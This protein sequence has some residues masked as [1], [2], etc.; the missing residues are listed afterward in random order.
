MLF[1]SHRI[2]SRAAGS[3][4]SAQSPHAGLKLVSHKSHD[5][6]QSQRLDQLGHPGAS[7]YQF[8]KYVSTIEILKCMCLF[9]NATNKAQ[10]LIE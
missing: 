6:S 2:Q 1:R 3:E 8:L 10:L 5:L 7:G 9:I 4:L